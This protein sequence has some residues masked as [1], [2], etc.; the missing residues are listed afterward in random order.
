MPPRALLLLD[1]DGVVNV[2]HGYVH[3]PEDT[4][5]VD[6]IFELAAEASAAGIGIVVCTNQAGIGRGYYSDR[7]F[8]SYMEWMHRQFERN[9]SPI[10]RTYYCPH[11][12]EAACDDYAQPCDFRK[13]GPGMLLAAMRHFGVDATRCLMIGDQETDMQAAAAAGVQGLQV[14]DSVSTV[15]ATAREYLKLISAR[16]TET[17]VPMRGMGG[18]R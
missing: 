10:L 7:Q 13:P 9:G 3:R 1:R 5:W 17:P 6:G 14:H 2:N 12:P 18:L 16:L 11:H 8:R 4:E 15:A